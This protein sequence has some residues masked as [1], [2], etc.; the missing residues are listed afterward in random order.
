MDD[1]RPLRSEALGDLGHPGRGRR[2]ADAQQLTPCPGWV[3]QRAQE[4]E[5]RPDADLAPG[6][7]RMFHRGVEVRGEHERETD[8]AKGRARGRRIVVDADPEGVEDVG[9]SS[10]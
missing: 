3:R 10:P 8:L 2:I 1:E 9:G 4:V 7:P 5:R 6:R